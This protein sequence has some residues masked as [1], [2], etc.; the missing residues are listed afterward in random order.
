VGGRLCFQRARRQLVP[1][2]AAI[3]SH[4]ALLAAPLS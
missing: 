4:S 2:V 3:R 1:V